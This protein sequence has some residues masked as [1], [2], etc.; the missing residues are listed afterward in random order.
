MWAFAGGHIAARFAYEWHD[1][2]G[3][4]FRSHGNE[5]WAF[6]ADGL[7]HRREASINDVPINEV[8]RLSADCLGR[9]P[10]PIQGCSH[11]ALN[12]SCF[13]PLSAQ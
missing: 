10:G 4:W 5:Q 8:D 12:A 3:R 13:L 6:D 2:E 7:A 1:A 9:G 11:C